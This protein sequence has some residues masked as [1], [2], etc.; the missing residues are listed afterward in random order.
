VDPI[1]VIFTQLLL[2]AAAEM[3]KTTPE[4]SANFAEFLLHAD[5]PKGCSSIEYTVVAMS[6]R[7]SAAE[8]RSCDSGGAFSNRP[9][10]SSEFRIFSTRAMPMSTPHGLG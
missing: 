8:S 10:G 6:R 3:H 2:H 7:A 4:H 9:S 5:I 1:A